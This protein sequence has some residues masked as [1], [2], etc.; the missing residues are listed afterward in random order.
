MITSTGTT[1]LL[2]MVMLWVSLT[3]T[4]PAVYWAVMIAAVSAATAPAV[5]R[6]VASMVA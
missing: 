6:P 1:P 3:V 4:A 5:S 2:R